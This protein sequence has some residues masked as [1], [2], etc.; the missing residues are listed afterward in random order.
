METP[1]ILSGDIC[2]TL[3]TVM[4]STDLMFPFVFFFCCC[5]GS[6]GIAVTLIEVSELDSARVTSVVVYECMWD[7][8]DFKLGPV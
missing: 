8:F 6:D 7:P 3:C 1:L 4:S 5:K 2:K